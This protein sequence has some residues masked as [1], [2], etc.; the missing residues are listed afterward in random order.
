VC[1]VSAMIVGMPKEARL[2]GQLLS[3]RVTGHLAYQDF[4]CTVTAFIRTLP[5]YEALPRVNTLGS[6]PSWSN[7]ALWK[8]AMRSRVFPLAIISLFTPICFIALQA[9][10]S[11]QAALASASHRRQDPVRQEV[12][13]AC[14]VT[15]LPAQPFV[16]PPPYWTNHGPDAF[17]FGTPK[18]WILLPSSGT[19]NVGRDGAPYGQKQSWY[20]EGFDGRRTPLGPPCLY[21]EPGL[22]VTGEPLGSP[23]PPLVAKANTVSASPP[24]IMV[25][26]DIPAL[27]CWKITGRYEDTDLS[28]VVSVR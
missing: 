7:I 11:T 8:G 6:H 19:W 17:W 12:L 13:E 9:P 26:F 23:A 22:K 15:K 20:R 27:G 2:S 14:P 4:S 21:C 16:P 25:A 24:Y 5:R 1:S 28:F 10:H 18:L 3:C